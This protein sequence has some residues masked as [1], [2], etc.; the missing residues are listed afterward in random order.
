[1]IIKPNKLQLSSLLLLLSA[2]VFNNTM[3]K[4]Q[5]QM[6]TMEARVAQREAAIARI[7]QQQRTS[8]AA[9]VQMAAAPKPQVTTAETSDAPVKFSPAQQKL[10]QQLVN[11]TKEENKR[12]WLS[13]L[14]SVVGGGL[15]GAAALF[16]SLWFTKKID[17]KTF[18]F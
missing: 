7:K 16:A 13:Y 4:V 11:Q 14:P 6:L 9:T 1:M 3:A 18:G 15:A 10:V 8:S 12:S 5:A 17:K 2:A